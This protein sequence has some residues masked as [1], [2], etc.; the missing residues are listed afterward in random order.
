MK[1]STTEYTTAFNAFTYTNKQLIGRRVKYELG[2]TGF[3]DEVSA[4]V[5]G[6][7]GDFLVMDNG[8]EITYDCLTAIGK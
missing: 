7:S 3:R 2:C 8:Y 5:A 4:V 1:E 6:V